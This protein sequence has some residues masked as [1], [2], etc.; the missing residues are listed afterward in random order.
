M[1]KYEQK[2]KQTELIYFQTQWAYLVQWLA[3]ALTCL[4]VGWLAQQMKTLSLYSK[5]TLK[6]AGCEPPTAPTL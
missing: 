1:T 6:A 3:H 5:S 4:C 2:F